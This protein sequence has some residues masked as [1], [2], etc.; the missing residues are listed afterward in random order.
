MRDPA[1]RVHT[2]AFYHTN[3]AGKLA[4]AVARRKHRHFAAVEQRVVEADGALD[5]AHENQPAAVRDTFEAF[6]HRPNAARGVKNHFRQA[7]VRLRQHF[8]APALGEGPP[9]RI[10][11]DHAHAPSGRESEL[12]DRQSNRP[13]ADHQ[14]LLPGLELA[15][16]DGVRPDA[17]RLDQDQLIEAESI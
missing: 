12:E 8:H 16:P 5:H 11:F 17:E 7:L 10:D 3:D 6:L 9:Q 2:P 13:G 4:D 15:S 1:R 14:D